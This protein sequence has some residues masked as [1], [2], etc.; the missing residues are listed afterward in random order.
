VKYFTDALLTLP[1]QLR[2]PGDVTGDPRGLVRDTP[3]ADT[4][5][6]WLGLR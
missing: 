3:T 5:Q 2:Q 6:G 4:R 1:E